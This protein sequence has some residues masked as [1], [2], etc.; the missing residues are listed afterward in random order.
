M[1][2]GTV[3][4]SGSA[5]SPLS[6]PAGPNRQARPAG[7]GL[8]ASAAPSPGRNADRQNARDRSFFRPAHSLFPFVFPVFRFPLGRKFRPLQCFNSKSSKVLHHASSPIFR[9][10]LFALRP[11]PASPSAPPDQGTVLV[12]V[13]KES[14]SSRI[15]KQSSPTMT[16][17]KASEA[18][19]TPAAVQTF[20]IP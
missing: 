8:T 14:T 11:W 15:M 1:K 17:A 13:L 5:A 3:R 7:S 18:S 20:Q 2:A 19:V 16:R 10:D 12:S 4:Q 6:W 9:T